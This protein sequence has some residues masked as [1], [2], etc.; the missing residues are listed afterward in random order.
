MLMTIEKIMVVGVARGGFVGRRKKNWSKNGEDG[1]EACK[2]RT[3]RGKNDSQ[4]NAKRGSVVRD[5][6]TGR[7]RSDKQ[8]ERI[9]KQNYRR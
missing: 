1:L 9:S 4:I 2:Q 8:E 3:P 6:E 7:E 5:K